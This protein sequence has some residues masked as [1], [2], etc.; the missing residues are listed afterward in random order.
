METFENIFNK[1]DLL[2]SYNFARSSDIVYSEV[3]LREQFQELNI[4]DPLIIFEDSNFIFY[5]LNEFELKENN[6]IFC[7][8]Y[9]IDSLFRLLKNETSFKNIKLIT[10]QSDNSIDKKLFMTKPACI[11]EWY[12]TNVA[13]SNDKLIPVPLG[14]ANYHPKNL[15]YEHFLETKGS[16][17]KKELAYMNFEKNTNFYKRNKIIN[18]LRPKDWIHTEES[19]ISLEDYLSKLKSYTFIISPPGNGIDTHRVWEA[20]YAGS[21][22]VVEKNLS[23]N[24]FN[25]FPIIFVDHLSKAT[26]EQVKSLKKNLNNFNNEILKI[27]YWMEKINKNRLDD[28][29][30]KLIIRD[31]VES[32]N[33]ALQ[34]YKKNIRSEQRLKKYKTIF[35]RV[36]SLIFN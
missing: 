6:I 1:E 31:E 35:R 29:I 9:M 7:N 26:F 21:H 23:M 12:S 30:S 15:K 33:K 32:I 3:V 25:E 19:L 10:S 8:L 20:I 2:C 22:P 18:K 17:T 36:Y 27:N 24:V 28:T 5:K 16:K 11:S 13:Y 34:N 4:K 14:L